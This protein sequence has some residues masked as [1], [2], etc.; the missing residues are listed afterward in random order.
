[1]SKTAPKITRVCQ[2]CWYDI[3]PSQYFP[4]VV[5]YNCCDMCGEVST[6]T[7]RVRAEELKPVDTSY[8]TCKVYDE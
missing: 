1:M 6:L 3:R 8:P 2:D 5:V 7:A 4:D